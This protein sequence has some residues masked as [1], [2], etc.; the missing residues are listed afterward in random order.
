MATAL[1]G[2]DT[3]ALASKGAVGAV[4]RLNAAQLAWLGAELDK[5]PAA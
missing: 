5:A 1:A 2:R 4:C 3:A